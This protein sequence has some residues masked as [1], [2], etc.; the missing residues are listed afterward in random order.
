MHIKVLNGWSNKSFDMLLELLKN[1]FPIG[2]SIPS[3]FYEAKKKLRD[4]GLGYDLIHTCKFDCILYWKEFSDSQQCPVCHEPRYIINDVK[5]KKIP[6]KVL[7]H[8]PMIPRSKRLFASRH[9]A[10]EM[11]WHKEKHVV[12][13]DTLDTQLMEKGGNILT[14][15][16]LNL[17][18]TQGMF[19]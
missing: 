13:D 7:C 8:F 18:Q 3:S 11:R 6:H 1:A 19:G 9:V 10:S 17:L 12:T 2:A 5:G 4:L 15:N 14:V 16:F